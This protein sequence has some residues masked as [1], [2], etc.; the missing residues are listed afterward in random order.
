M[1]ITVKFG[2]QKKKRGV[3]EQVEKGIDLTL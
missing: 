1:G 3:E 2:M